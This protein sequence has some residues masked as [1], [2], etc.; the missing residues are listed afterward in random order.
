MSITVQIKSGDPEPRVV[1]VSDEGG[2]FSMRCTCGEGSSADWC[3]HIEAVVLGDRAAMA[4]TAEIESLLEA[5]KI[6]E[7]H[8]DVT[9]AMHDRL[10]V[11]RG[12]PD[13]ATEAQ[14]LEAAL[15]NRLSV[16][17]P[18]PDDPNKA[19]KALVDRVAALTE[20]EAEPQSPPPA[21]GAKSGS[22]E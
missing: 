2:S 7:R 20:D 4:T 16:Q 19:A 12:D 3:P 13:R 11:L 17:R 1:T 21:N 15:A 8:I 6:M 10:K 22:P 18:P 14:A 9:A 5:G